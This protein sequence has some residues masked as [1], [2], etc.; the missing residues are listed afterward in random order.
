MYSSVRSLD[1]VQ[2]VAKVLHLLH[3]PIT[4]RLWASSSKRVLGPYANLFDKSFAD[5]LKVLNDCCS[6]QT[7]TDFFRVDARKRHSTRN[8]RYLQTFHCTFHAGFYSKQ[9]LTIVI[10][11]CKHRFNCRFPGEPRKIACF[12]LSAMYPTHYI[13]RHEGLQS[14]ARP[15]LTATG[16]INGRG[17]FST[18]TG[19]SCAKFGRNPSTKA[20]GKMGEI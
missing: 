11:H 2:S 1:N 19:Y 4:I 10:S 5:N 16:F 7:E 8:V 18:P 17:Q 3:R 12:D 14:S 6:V 20:S 15:V 9:S 13:F